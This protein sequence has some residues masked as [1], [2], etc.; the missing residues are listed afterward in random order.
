MKKKD[1]EKNIK[2]ECEDCNCVDCNCDG[3][4]C[5]DEGCCCGETCDCEE[6]SCEH[7]IVSDLQYVKSSVKQELIMQIFNNYSLI[8]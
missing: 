5:C 6:C 1:K 2:C 3:E 4:E 8:L 7:D